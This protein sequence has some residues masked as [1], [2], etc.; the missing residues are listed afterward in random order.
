[1]LK[2]MGWLFF[3]SSVSTN[4][5]PND[6]TNLVQ[7]KNEQIYPFVLYSVATIFLFT[8]KTEQGVQPIL[9]TFSA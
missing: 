9:I 4:K 7:S 8:S 6:K 5:K 2:K 3:F 1:M